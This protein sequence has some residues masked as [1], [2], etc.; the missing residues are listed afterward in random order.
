[1]LLK[2][3]LQHNVLFHCSSIF[4]FSPITVKKHLSSSSCVT[5]WSLLFQL[6]KMCHKQMFSTLR[7][8]LMFLFFGLF[9]HIIFH[10]TEVGTMLPAEAERREYRD[11]FKKQYWFDSV[12][13]NNLLPSLCKNNVCCLCSLS[14][15]EVGLEGVL[16]KC[17]CRDVEVTGLFTLTVNLTVVYIIR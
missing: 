4:Q 7:I 13:Q 16:Q 17:F 3:L 14:L 2:P 9:F 8:C 15:N 10:L 11:F 1:M 6:V 12:H 5:L